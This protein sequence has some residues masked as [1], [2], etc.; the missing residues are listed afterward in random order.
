MKNLDIAREKILNDIQREVL[1]II[2]AD[3]IK[4]AQEREEVKAYFK[5]AVKLAKKW[6]IFDLDEYE[7]NFDMDNL[8]INPEYRTLLMQKVNRK[9]RLANWK[10]KPYSEITDSDNYYE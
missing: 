6:D 3:D 10:G 1:N 5:E 4:N 2:H 7:G 8:R 9:R